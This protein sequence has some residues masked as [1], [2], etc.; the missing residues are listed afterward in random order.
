MTTNTNTTDMQGQYSVTIRYVID[1]TASMTPII[2]TVKGELLALH[3]QL[4]AA[5]AAKSKVVGKLQ[6]GVDVFRDVYCDGTHAFISSRFFDMATE[7]AELQKFVSA[8]HPMGGG[9]EPENGL[10]GL[11]LALNATWPNDA[12]KQRHVVVVYTDASAHELE[13]AAGFS[14]PNYPANMPKTFSE[15]TDRWSS[16]SMDRNAKRLILFAPD[17]YPW[18]DIATNWENCVHYASRAG[19][20][21]SDVDSQTILDAIVNSIAV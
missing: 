13:K 2:D 1:G 19:D 16:Q 20:G 4:T 18:T 9:D 17:A 21:L 8:V 11:T 5:L 10:E 3:G 12:A 14:Q 7:Q 6:V 15:L